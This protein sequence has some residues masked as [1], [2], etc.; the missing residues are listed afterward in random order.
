[1]YFNG[2]SSY[3]YCDEVYRWNSKYISEHIQQDTHLDERSCRKYVS[4]L[5][6]CLTY[7]HGVNSGM[8]FSIDILRYNLVIVWP[9]IA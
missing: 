8:V 7:L 6:V 3:R 2:K 4:Y 9:T 5:K 1:M